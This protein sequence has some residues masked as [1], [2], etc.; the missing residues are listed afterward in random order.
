MTIRILEI[1]RHRTVWCPHA[2]PA[3]RP[4]CLPS[5][6]GISGT[7]PVFRWTDES[8]GIQPCRV[9]IRILIRNGACSGSRAAGLVMIF[10]WLEPVP[11]YIPDISSA[12]TGLFPVIRSLN[13]KGSHPW[14]AGRLSSPLNTSL[15]TAVR[16]AGCLYRRI[17]QAARFPSGKGCP[18]RNYIRLSVLAAMAAIGTVVS[19]IQIATLYFALPSLS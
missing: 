4:S 13:T 19:F 2:G 10:A 6:N 15:P 1:I 18:G 14:F 17:L 5:P 11:P 7:S 3:A 12:G 8:T 9:S 16:R